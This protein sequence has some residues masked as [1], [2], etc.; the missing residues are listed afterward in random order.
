MTL[1]FPLTARTDAPAVTTGISV[2][3]ADHGH[4]SILLVE[5]EESVRRL[6]QRVLE[7]AGY[8]VHVAANGAEALE[9][10]AT[11]RSVIALVITDLIMPVMGGVALARILAEKRPG[12]PVVFTS[13]YEGEPIV[14]A[15]LEL[16]GHYFIAKP[17]SAAQLTSLVR[18]VI[19][20]AAVQS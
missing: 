5:D 6:G 19:D 2:P 16:P 9:I 15:M 11:T 18:N 4:E 14:G 7:R 17:Y 8:R 3:A 20:R 12:L 1:L 10:V 13:G